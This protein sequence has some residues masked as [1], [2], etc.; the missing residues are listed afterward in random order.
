MNM[1]NKAW[2]LAKVIRILS[3]FGINISEINFGKPAWD[4]TPWYIYMEAINPSK[5][6]FVIRQLD[7]YSNI[8][9]I[10]DRKFI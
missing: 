5:F 4:I 3:D 7:K 1:T 10:T 2:N 8:L 6:W 9:E